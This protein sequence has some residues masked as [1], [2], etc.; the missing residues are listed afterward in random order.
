MKPCDQRVVT[1]DRDGVVSLV[2]WGLMALV[3]LP[4][5]LGAIA[6]PLLAVML[7]LAAGGLTFS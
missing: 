2:L 3:A 6:Q 5:G 1:V 4:L 7:L